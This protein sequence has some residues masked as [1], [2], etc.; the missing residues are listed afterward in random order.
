MGKLWDKAQKQHLTRIFCCLST[1]KT[2]KHMYQLSKNGTR[3]QMCK[4]LQTKSFQ[5]EWR[6]FFF[7]HLVEPELTIGYKNAEI[8]FKYSYKRISFIQMLSINV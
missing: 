8:H 7:L 3:G 4:Q 5:E 1:P 2:Y 6:R